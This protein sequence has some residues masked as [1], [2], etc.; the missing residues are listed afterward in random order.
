[1]K[2]ITSSQDS[3]AVG[4]ILAD[5]LPARIG[6]AVSQYQTEHDLRERVKE[7]T[8]IRKISEPF[9]AVNPNAM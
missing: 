9:I 2:L 3:L 5:V 7:L 1:L 8:A 6:H 4:E